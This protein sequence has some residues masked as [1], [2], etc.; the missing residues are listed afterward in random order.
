M[1]ELVVGVMPK[2]LRNPYFEACAQGAG[3]AARE[4]GFT[5]RWEG[6]AFPDAT[7]QAGHLT[8]WVGEGLP[9][10]AVSVEDR[11]GLSPVLHEARERG[12][13]VL[14]WDADADPDARDFTVTPATADGIAQAL[15]FEMGRM[16]GGQGEVGIITSTL[17]APN[18]TAWL[19]RLRARLARELPGIVIA[20]VVTCNDREERALRAAEGLLAAHPSLGA[21]V[22]LCSPAVPGAARALRQRGREDVHLTGISLPSI[23]RE[24]LEAGW[25]DSVVAWNARDLGYLAAWAAAALAEGELAPDVLVL[26]AGR[27]GN[28]TVEGDEVRLGRPHIVTVGNLESFVG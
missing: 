16:L 19:E 17:T 9:V 15:A 14:T 20:D 11:T 8:R 28:V 18:Q 22:G 10:V 25:V 5:L 21:L 24:D 13:K 4:R 2:E 23:C 27:L 7:A 6:P 12:V 1:G 26:E 3:E